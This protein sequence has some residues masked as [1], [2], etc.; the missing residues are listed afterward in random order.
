MSTSPPSFL[1]EIPPAP[2]AIRFATFG[3]HPSAADHLEDLGL[4]TPSLT[5]FKQGLY[6]DGIITCL[7]RQSWIKYVPAMT[8]V[9]YDHSLLVIGPASWIAARFTQSTDTSGRDQFPLVT[10]IHGGGL[11]LLRA[12]TQIGQWL[13]QA[14]ARMVAAKDL[15]PAHAECQGELAALPAEWEKQPPQGPAVRSAWAEDPALA[16]A[17]QGLW[18]VCHAVLPSGAAGGRARLPM[19]AAGTPAQNAVLWASWLRHLMPGRTVCLIWPSAAAYCDVTFNVPDAAALSPLFAPPEASPLTT[20]VPFSIEPDLEQ[21]A[22][23]ALKEWLQS[24]P[25]FPANNQATKTDGFA[26]KLRSWLGR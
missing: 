23:G 8:P 6:T 15:R 12:A 7:A 25:L 5:A 14:H 3:K 24:G 13:D 11:E 20:T 10:A 9:P 22:D 2:A 18:R 1:S 4:T 17:H 19:Q 16:P 21:R 26:S